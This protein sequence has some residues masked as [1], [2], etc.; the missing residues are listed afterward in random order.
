[1]CGNGSQ[2]PGESCD[3]GNTSNNDACP[4]DCV[5]APCTPIVPSDR[6]IDV[7]FA[8][9]VGVGVAGITVLVNYPEG[10][11]IIPG[12]GNGLPAGTITNTP[13]GASAN[14]NDFDH[15]LREV[16]VNA[17]NM[18]PG[19][20]FRIHTQNC[21]GAPAPAAADFTCTVL[22]ASDQNGNDVSGVTC[23]VA[24]P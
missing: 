9:P 23:T 16:V 13:S 10:K 12:S 11:V 20:L 2:E 22:D 8:P 21:Q 24:V 15:A 7:N 6:P 1:V 17:T 4:S 5:I 18:P 19:L 3:D 14:S